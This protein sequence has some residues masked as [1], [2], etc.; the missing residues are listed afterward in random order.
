M[1]K[2]R[3]TKIKVIKQRLM[4]P[5]QDQSRVTKNVVDCS[6]GKNICHKSVNIAT[7]DTTKAIVLI[8]EGIL[9]EVLKMNKKNPK[10]TTKTTTVINGMGEELTGIQKVGPLAAL[11]KIDNVWG[12]SAKYR[13]LLTSSACQ[14]QKLNT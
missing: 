14:T 5:E 8:G 11:P 13:K 6:I 9:L 2:I 10:M 3:G 12:T 7:N 1:V 4:T